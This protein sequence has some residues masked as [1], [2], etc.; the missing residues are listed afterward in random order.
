[1]KELTPYEIFQLEKYGNILSEIIN[2]F[3][4]DEDDV[5]QDI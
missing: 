1:M 3:S 4:P 5:Q 2:P